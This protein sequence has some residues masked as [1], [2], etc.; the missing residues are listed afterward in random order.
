MERQ[1]QLPPP[2]SA[3]FAEPLEECAGSS[4][5]PATGET[6]APKTIHSRRRQRRIGS[7]ATTAGGSETES[8]SNQDAPVLHL[9]I[10][11]LRLEKKAAPEKNVTG[12]TSP[13]LASPG[14]RVDERPSP[15]V[16]AQPHPGVTQAAQTTTGNETGQPEVCGDVGGSKESQIQQQTPAAVAVPSEPSRGGRSARDLAVGESGPLWNASGH[17]H[18]ARPKRS[19]LTPQEQGST[20]SEETPSITIGKS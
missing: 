10:R 14:T 19:L 8:T 2:A 4:T 3:P 1:D 11:L 17:M 20:P 6:L 15:V 13:R 16:V 9:E 18:G 7:T 12:Q 5:L